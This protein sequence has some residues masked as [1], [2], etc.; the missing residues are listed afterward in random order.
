MSIQVTCPNPECAKGLR[1][2]DDLAGQKVKCP[3]CGGVIVVPGGTTVPDPLIGK[4]I[5]HYQILAK[6]GQGGMGSVY[7]ARNLRLSKIV[8]LKI[9]PPSLTA[10]D[11]AFVERFIREAQSTAQLDHPNVVT[12]HFVGS[13]AGHHFIEM[14]YVDGKTLAEILRDSERL[15]P[16][17]ATRIVIEAAR[18]L[19]AAHLKKIIH[20]DVKPD[21]IILT[22]DGHVKVADFG[23]AA[24]GSAGESA[25]AGGKV[26]GTPYFMSPEHCRGEATD[27]RSDIYSLGAT[28]Y[29]A[30][31]G[32]PPFAGAPI[33]EVTKMQVSAI[34]PRPREI[35]P[36]IPASVDD[37]VM[38]M[39]EKKPEKRYPSCTEL[40]AD[41][42]K[43]HATLSP[44][45]AVSAGIDEVE[46]YRGSPVF[47]KATLVIVGIALLGA[48]LLLGLIVIPR[49]SSTRDQGDRPTPHV[50]P[51]PSSPSSR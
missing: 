36:D 22:A 26:L 44:A 20:R 38:R 43:L 30:L 49:L 23:L 29:H 33:Q 37:A 28:F 32:R 31:T 5:A 18:A 21:N 1:L 6:I 15:S 3:D 34:L 13:D 16:S 50:T 46:Q 35:V 45:A 41:L 25:M 7:R 42:E 14:Q 17:E 19:E 12:V 39:L 8:A 24:L 27:A 47:A 2:R 9:L 51:S 40:I 4:S 48:G 11:P 10:T